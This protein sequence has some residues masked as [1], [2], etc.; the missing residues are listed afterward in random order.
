MRSCLFLGFAA[1]L[2]AT[3]GCESVDT[4]PTRVRE[5]FE[6]PRPQVRTF[7]VNSRAVF[8]AAVVA[9]RR[10]DFRVVRS[11]AAQGT[12][13]ALSRI[14]PG[15]SFGTGRQYA[16]DVH[17]RAVE[18]DRTEVSVLLREQEESTSFAG[19]TDLP[20]REHGLYGSYFDAIARELA[21]VPAG[22]RK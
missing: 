21:S 9:F 15:G 16:M 19:A 20:V 4:V 11:G 6:P 5:R 3:I 17:V 1:V 8:G 18:P 14:Q 22:P 7:E 13:S 2:L 12:I 10:I